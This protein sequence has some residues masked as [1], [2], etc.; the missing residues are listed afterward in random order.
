M[1][2]HA[3]K[4]TLANN[5]G[6]IRNFESKEPRKKVLNTSFDEGIPKINHFER[7]TTT[8]RRTVDGVNEKTHCSKLNAATKRFEGN[9]QLVNK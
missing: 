7:F 1:T 3:L 4:G 8:D 6:K 2:E 9:N 5:R